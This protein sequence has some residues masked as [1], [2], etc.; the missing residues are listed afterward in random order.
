M[1]ELAWLVGQRF[2]SITRREYDW[3]I[4]LN[5]DASIV[6]ACL[7]RLVE[8]DRIRITSEDEGQKFG[9]PEPVEA[10]AEVN[11]RLTAAGK[12]G[13]ASHRSFVVVKSFR[14]RPFR[15]SNPRAVR[16]FSVSKNDRSN[17]S[18]SRQ[19]VF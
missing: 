2:Q 7:W 17:R 1:N 6:V 10:A 13:H 16:V 5:N 15:Q 4:A 3:V 19:A 8:T 11:R 9:L 18:G 12:Q 14:H